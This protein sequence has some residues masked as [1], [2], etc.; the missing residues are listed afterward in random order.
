MD[1]STPA[2]PDSD[3]EQ[4]PEAVLELGRLVAQALR[5]N[6]TDLMNLWI[7]TRIAELMNLAENGPDLAV[8]QE[9]AQQCQELIL[10]VWDRRNTWGTGWPPRRLEEI[11]R[12]LDGE[13]PLFDIHRR[14]VEQQPTTWTDVLA[15]ALISL[16]RERNVWLA[17]AAQETPSDEPSA[18]LRVLQKIEDLTSAGDLDDDIEGRA[19]EQQS[20]EALRALL[21]RAS[22][23]TRMTRSRQ[24]KTAD[25][26]RDAAAQLRA[27][28]QERRTWIRHISSG[29]AETSRAPASS[30]ETS[31]CAAEN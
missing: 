3:R 23:K 26:Q 11:V 24:R 10:A 19:D 31:V 7:A 14:T 12:A 18:W 27:L 20:L 16:D 25:P 21:D 4:L 1:V 30:S 28:W 5:T 9:A 2:S 15:A 17:M 13:D 29:G 8:R 22:A 6:Q